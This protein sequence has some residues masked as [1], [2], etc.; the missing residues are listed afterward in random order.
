MK[1]KNDF[2][3]KKAWSWPDR[4]Q[5]FFKQEIKGKN[6]LHVFCG[7]SD[8]GTV[9]VDIENNGTP[10]HIADILKGLPFKDDSFDV[11]FGDPPWNIAVHVRSKMMYEMRRVCKPHGIIILNA[12]WNP[13]NLRGCMLLEPLY[14]SGGRMPFG[15][16]AMIAKYLKLFS[17]QEILRII[18]KNQSEPTQENP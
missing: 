5:K 4:V 14:I 15:N 9:R 10:T 7:T 12:N 18:S 13:N 6:S 8:L 16:C 17:E 11:V 1:E 2:K 3:F